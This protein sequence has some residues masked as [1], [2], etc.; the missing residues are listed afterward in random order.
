MESLITKP[1][2]NAVGVVN[3]VVRSVSSSPS[4]TSEV[5]LEFRRLILLNAEPWMLDA[6]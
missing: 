4:D 2:E 3:N 6:D 1:I 5:T